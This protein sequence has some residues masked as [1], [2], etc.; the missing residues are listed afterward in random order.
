LSTPTEVIVVGAGAAGISAARELESLRCSCILLEARSRVGGRAW[1]DRNFFGVPV[2]MGC[3]WLHSADANPWRESAIAA[4]FHVIERSPH[5]QRRIGRQEASAEYTAAWRG[6]FG[7]NE[8]LIAQA[9]QR[10][11]DVAV[12][13]VVPDDDFRPMFDAV[14][15]WLMGVD[16]DQVSTLDFDRYE[17]SN[18][19]WAVRE[20]LGDVISHAARGLDVRLDTAVR[21]I[22]W[23]GDGV[24]VLTSRG[25]LEARAVIVTAPTAVLAA[26]DSIAFAPALPLDLVEAFHSLPLGADDKVF[27]ELTPGAMPFEGTLNFIGTDRTRR[28]AAYETRPAEQEVLL[29]FFGGG[30]ARELEL[31]GE[32]EACAREQLTQI[33][34]SDFSRHLRRAVSTRW[35]QDPWARGSYSAALPGHARKRERL[36]IPVGDRIYFAGEAA[37]VSSFGTI[38]GA[39]ER[40]QATARRVAA[41]LRGPQAGPAVR[42]Q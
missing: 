31:R 9:V 32:L 11:Q 25:D 7:R 5:W 28:T 29:A 26:G 16:T 27:F 33:F 35:V 1:T 17:D 24:R 20:G 40:G 30:Y 2:D 14:M 21:T 36:N 37:S 12:A 39:R 19:N 18:C 41:R 13:S 10:G 42:D 34:G 23:R 6:A 4:G 8:A 22:D 3:A 15:G 38:H